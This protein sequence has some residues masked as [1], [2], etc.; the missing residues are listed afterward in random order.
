MEDEEMKSEVETT[1]YDL[2][3]LDVILDNEADDH[4]SNG[5]DID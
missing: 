4:V 2:T 5:A 3:D 1:I